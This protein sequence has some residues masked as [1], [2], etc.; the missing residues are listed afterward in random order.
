VE[1]NVV[2]VGVCGYL[3]RLRAG[4]AIIAHRGDDEDNSF[5]TENTYALQRGGSGPK[6]KISEKRSRQLEV[7][8]KLPGTRASETND[9]VKI[10]MLK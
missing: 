2:V 6:A 4:C 7:K 1:G 8:L 10:T 5:S 9:F 3:L